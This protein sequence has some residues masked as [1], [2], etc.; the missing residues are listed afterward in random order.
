MDEQLVGL[1]SEAK[2]LPKDALRRAVAAPDSVAEAVLRVVDLTA[3]NPDALNDE[4][5]N[6]LFWGLHALAAA[7]DTRLFAPLLRLLRQDSETLDGLLGD[8]LTI[9]LPRVLA[10]SFDGQADALFR[11]ILDST[12]DDAVTSSALTAMSF[13][14]REGLIALD[15]A[16][17]LLIRF[18]DARVA[19]EDSLGWSGWEQAIAYLGLSD[20]APRVEAARKDGRIT[21]E[22]SD[23]PWFRRAL[24]QVTSEPPSFEAFEGEA[25]GYLDDPVRQLAWTAE[26]AGQPVKN[27]FKDVGRNDPCPCGSGKKYKKCCLNLEQPAQLPGLS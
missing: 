13:L 18:D 16:K 27:P 15:Q 5:A 1:L 10:G 17:T 24:R 25:Y 7:R 21:D 14:V 9:T 12:I 4:E 2:F 11:L 20:L 8:A 23:L 26:E 3:E 19:V 6:L 22:F